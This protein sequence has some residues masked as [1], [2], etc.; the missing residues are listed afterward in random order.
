M[1]ALVTTSWRNALRHMRRRPLRTFLTLLQVFLAA[2]AMTLA[3]SAYLGSIAPLVPSQIFQ[4][5]VQ[6]P[7]ANGGS[8][9]YYVFHDSELPKLKGLTSAAAQMAVDWDAYVPEVDAQGERFQLRSGALVSASYPDIVPITLTRGSFFTPAEVANY[10]FFVLLS[11][12]AAKVIFGNANPVGQQV[13]IPVSFS[14]FSPNAKMRPYQV[15][16][17]FSA[18]AEVR[19]TYDVPAMLVP[20]WHGLE[21]PGVA[22]NKLWVK[23]LPGKGE[24]ARAEVLAAAEQMYGDQVQEEAAQHGQSLE[25]GAAFSIQEPGQQTGGPSFFNPNV[26][27]FALFGII[28]LIIGAIGIFSI[29]TVDV[30]ERTHEI[31]I[32][33]SLGASRSRITVEVVLEAAL[34]AA[35]GGLL[36]VGA[37]AGVIPWVASRVGQ[38]LF[39]GVNL[40]WQPLAALVV[41]LVVIVVGAGLGLIPAVQASR[42]KPVEALREV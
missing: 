10:S 31:G 13:E 33:R 16:G 22:A 42:M 19:S 26:L 20:A 11:D 34:L 35:L 39:Y 9:P 7:N 6:T 24:A 29:T 30:T 36:G 12:D 2:L 5:V 18:S 17:T 32:R 15:I 4:V 28:A 25:K 38:T 41:F 14:S 8:T 3:L 37:A 21:G 23:A 40:S 27:T 1:L